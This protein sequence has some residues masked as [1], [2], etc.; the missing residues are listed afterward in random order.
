MKNGRP[1]DVSTRRGRQI[2]LPFSDD[3]YRARREKVLAGM[4]ERG[5]DVMV[6]STPSNCFYLTG[7]RAGLIHYL[8][9][10]ALT[11]K[12]EGIWIAGAQ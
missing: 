2:G 8:F 5:I 7:M 6:M 12:G 3:E 1:E 11:R 9:V 10:L 4:D